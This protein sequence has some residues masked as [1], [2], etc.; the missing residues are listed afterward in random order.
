MQYTGLDDRERREVVDRLDQT[1]Q[2]VA[3]EEQDV[4]DAAI[5]DLAQHLV[6]V[7]GALAAVA[8]PEAE[9]LPRPVDG[10]PDDGVEGP[11][12]DLAVADLDLDRV[13]DNHWVDRV[14]RPALPGLWGAK[15]SVPPANR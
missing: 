11:V 3:D 1:A 13:D 15:I 10:D 6:P 14:E 12:G 5:P 9:D 4:V 8:D 7:L 2:A